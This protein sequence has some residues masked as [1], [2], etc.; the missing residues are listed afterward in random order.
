M[1]I[2]E[3]KIDRSFI[4]DLDINEKN[5]AISRTIILLAKQFNILVTAEGIETEKQLN[6]LKEL[7]SDTGQG[8]YFSKPI[9]AKELEKLL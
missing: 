8:Y 4:W 9:P 3:L 7:G 5:R 2:D 6:I 1:N